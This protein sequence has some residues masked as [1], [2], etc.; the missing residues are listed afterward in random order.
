MAVHPQLAVSGRTAR[1]FNIIIPGNGSSPATLAALAKAYG[2]TANGTPWDD[3][4]HLLACMGGKVTGFATTF[5]A[6]RDKA[7]LFKVDPTKIMEYSENIVDFVQDTY[8]V[9]STSSPINA[10]LV[11]YFHLVPINLAKTALP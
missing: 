1:E 6:G 8:V 9:S 10:I 7:C 2:S 4:T 3:E 5:Y 11:A